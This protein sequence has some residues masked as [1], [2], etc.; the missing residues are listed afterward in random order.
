MKEVAITERGLRIVR[1]AGEGKRGEH[2]LLR[3]AIFETA[4]V[5]REDLEHILDQLEQ[6]RA[7]AG[8]P[9]RVRAA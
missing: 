1:Q 9:D 2:L 8:V 4:G 5:P 6:L 3:Q 7:T